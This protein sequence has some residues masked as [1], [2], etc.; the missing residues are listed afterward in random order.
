VKI[1]LKLILVLLFLGF[2]WGSSFILMKKGLLAFSPTQVASLRLIFAG[3]FA[4]FFF[5]RICRDLKKG[6]WLFLALSGTLGN[7]LPA[8][9]FASAAP[10]I[11]SSLSGALNALTPISTLIFGAILFHIQFKVKHIV[12]I[13]VGLC[14]ALILIF[15]NP[16]A[17]GL[18]L[19]YNYL[20]PCLKVILASLLYGINVNIIKSKLGHLPALTNSMVPLT[21]I[22]IPALFIG[23]SQDTY[24]A[25]VLPPSFMPVAY[26]GMPLVYIAILGLFGSAISLIVFNRLVKRS[27]ALFASSVTY[28]IPVFAFMWGIIDGEAIGLTQVSGMTLIMCGITLSK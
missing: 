12:G 22:A 9:L 16:K 4:V 8:Y 6:E 3:S 21:L 15:S 23:I 26:L 1:D 19:H 24:H 13:L 28:L 18:S 17:D 5:V 7:L 14:G 10:D 27:S 25:A 11:P 2:V 20:Y